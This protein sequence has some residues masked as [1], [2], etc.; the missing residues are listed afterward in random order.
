MLHP[1]EKLKI[2]P[3]LKELLPPLTESEFEQLEANILTSPE[4][5]AVV[6]WKE[7]E[8][9]LD[10]H[11]RYAV[12]RKNNLSYRIDQVSLPD[13]DAAKLW[14]INEHL[15]RRHFS[16]EQKSYWRAKQYEYQKK[17]HG[18]DRKSSDQNGHLITIEA[19]QQDRVSTRQAVAKEHRVGE[20]T[21]ERDVQFA[22]A[23]DTIAE[24][25]GGDAK[26]AILT[27]NVRM[28]RQEVQE[29]AEIAEAQPQV[30]KNILNKIKTAKRQDAK[31]I[32]AEAYHKL[33]NAKPTKPVPR[34][35][36][37][38]SAKPENPHTRYRKRVIGYVEACA[39]LPQPVDIKRIAEVASQTVHNMAKNA[40]ISGWSLLPWIEITP[41]P[42]SQ[43]YYFKIDRYLRA[44]CEDRVPRPST[45][46]AKS[47]EE[48][49]SLI[50]SLG[51]LRR[52]IT[53]RR[54]EAKAERAAS[55]WAPTETII[56]EVINLLNFIETA[57]DKLARLA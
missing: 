4:R 37:P 19:N 53:R 46:N 32:V 44:V 6:V 54:K 13:K 2:D 31:R 47:A 42:R 26:N 12:C 25:A 39:A 33:P 52:E 55:E 20:Q 8:V 5:V 51:D 56:P 3:E 29:V 28:T 11:N 18:G 23:V 38:A 22:R 34:K 50:A 49:K 57:L 43:S 24:A 10:G 35:R 36:M 40:A 27:R 30:A 7:K 45:S 1:T 9:L 16:E 17:D 14:V 15:G 48:L 41:D 21:I